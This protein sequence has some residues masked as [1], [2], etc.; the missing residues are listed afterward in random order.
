MVKTE[1]PAAPA[2]VEISAPA[3]APAVE[4]SAAPA[5]EPK[6]EAVEPPVETKEEVPPT[7]WF[8]DS[9]GDSVTLF[10]SQE[11]WSYADFKSELSE[12][13]AS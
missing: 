7:G 11:R 9:I 12:I 10:I 5:E 6:V 3:T 8:C 1:E 2:A 13:R 4:T